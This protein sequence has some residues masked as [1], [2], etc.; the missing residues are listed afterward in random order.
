MGCG[1][2]V[3]SGRNLRRNKY[4]WSSQ[5]LVDTPSASPIDSFKLLRTDSA[6]IAV[7]ACA[8]VERIDV[9][10]DVLG[11]GVTSREPERWGRPEPV[12]SLAKERAP[13]DGE[14]FFFY[15]ALV[16]VVRKVGRELQKLLDAVEPLDQV[17][18]EE[19]IEDTGGSPEFSD[20]TPEL[21]EIKEGAVSRLRNAETLLTIR[22]CCHTPVGG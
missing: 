18:L 6:K 1:E 3:G 13:A 9:I 16:R 22:Q 8:I 21:P 5:D 10:S 4:D 14:G 2:R 20:R 7:T 11:R 12:P 19:H 15:A 17:F